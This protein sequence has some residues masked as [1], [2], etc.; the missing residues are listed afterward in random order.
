M[1]KVLVRTLVAS[2]LVA[3][4]AFAVHAQDY[5]VKTVRVLIPWP[6]GGS[7]DIVG[8]LVAQ[9]LSENLKQQF[10]VDN[11]GGASGTIGSDV[12]AR[13][14]PDGYTIMIHSATHVANAHLYKKLPYDTLKDFAGITTL[15]RQVGMLIVHPSL[16][17]KS[18][19]EF[20]AL[21]KAR[22]N[23][24][25]Y[26]S[27]G[28][29]SYVHLAMAMVGSMAN[30]KMTHVPYKGGGPAVISII[31]G[32]TQAMLATIGSVLTQVKGGKL[33]PLAVSSDDRVKQFPDLPTLAESGVPGYEFTAWI[34][35]FAP[36]RTQPAIVNKLNAEL[37]KVLADAGVA[38]KLSAQTLDPMPMSPEQ[39]AK[40]LKSDYD[41]YARLMKEAGATMD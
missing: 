22:P 21:A 39:F 31:S 1:L 6:P 37:R 3:S 8:R 25:V 41:K 35:A 17:A 30:L 40:R 15:A 19:K 16:P 27:S 24:I 20:I 28:N 2:A 33:R 11:R 32:E 23:Q 4:T 34:G 18:M 5:P 13:S 7:N 36:A 10:V 26:A 29:G 14:E 9:K 12:L 38:Q